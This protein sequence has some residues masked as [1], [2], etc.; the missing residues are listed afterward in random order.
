MRVTRWSKEAERLF[1]WTAA[2]V[3]GK[4]TQDFR[5][6]HDEDVPSVAR[7]GI[8]LSKGGNKFSANRNYRKDGSVVHCEWY[9]SSLADETGQMR[10]I[11]SLV[12]DVTARKEAEAKLEEAKRLL[13]ALM[14]HVPEG[15]TIVRAADL[16]VQLVSRYGQ[17]LLGMVRT[18]VPA[19]DAVPGM[20]LYAADGVTPL[21]FED[22]PITRAI[23]RG[24]I[25]RDMEVLSAL[26]DGSRFPL[27]CNAA[28]IRDASGAIVGGVTAW[29]DLTERKRAEE[30]LLH[31]QK[32]E[33]IGLLAGGIAH[34]FNNLLVGVIGNASLALEMLGPRDPAAELLEQVIK[35]GEHASHLTRQM[36]AYSGK[37]RFVFEAV[38]VSKV[39]AQIAD[40]VR[41]SIPKKVTVQ[42]DLAPNLPPIKADPGQIQQVV[43]NLL[44]NGGEAIGDRIG[45]LSARTR[46]VEFAPGQ[47]F[48][49]FQGF[50]PEP[51]YYVSI[52]VRDTGAGMDEATRS[53]IFD[54]FFT[55]K[56]T[57][58]GLGLAAVSGILRG[59]KGAIR[60]E[61]E[62]GKGTCFEVLFPVQCPSEAP[63]PAEPPA[64]V[65]EPGRTDA[66]V[67][68][69]D[70]EDLVRELSARALQAAGFRVHAA[71]SGAE[72]AAILSREGDAIT[73]VL[74]DLSM[75][76]MD[77]VETLELLRQTH[78][79]VHAM[80][81]S[82]F[83]EQETMRLFQGL[84]VSGF[85]QKPYTAR[86][87]VNAV[88]SCLPARPQ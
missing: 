64:A 33:S 80:I 56:F 69:V 27:L 23:L 30:R 75:P 48:G 4:R 61:S 81:T 87:L 8:A 1:G 42:L 21:K 78:P 6:V 57:G 76:D 86:M 49:D 3:L 47:D 22:R 43:M 25:V 24:E 62:P 55:T 85:V 37:G 15:I 16:Q 54:T 60:V 39:V 32:L 63:P 44:I 67:L 31:A 9:N 36:L 53:R 58:R 35:S 52:E 2:E 7:V 20:Q 59:H 74:L 68:V 82:G 11:L 14:E 10:S 83:S 73:L 79:S 26:P 84:R 77:G 88:R 71:A 46:V 41:P 12:L 40:L 29:R 34:D 45:L 19:A 51:G 13:D 17:E 5:W 50:E 66:T 28:P 18:G 38:D 65:R 72:A 70:D